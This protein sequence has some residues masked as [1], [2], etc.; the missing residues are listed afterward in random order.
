MGQSS[1]AGK[2]GHSPS[3]ASGANGR[4][5]RFGGGPAQAP[6]RDRSRAGSRSRWRANRQQRTDP[7]HD[8]ADPNPN[9]IANEPIRLFALACLRGEWPP[10]PLRRRAGPGTRS[11]SFAS[12]FSFAMACQPAAANRPPPRPRG[13]EPERAPERSNSGYSPS[14]ASGA[15]GRSSR[16]G[17]KPLPKSRPS[18]TAFSCAK[19]WQPAAANRPCPRPR[20]PE[21]ERARERCDLLRA[22]HPRLTQLNSSG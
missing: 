8:H 7:L 6:D 19:A 4:P 11:R 15:N 18:A 21:P 10:F 2:G 16:F 1:V 3:L 14:L 5:S 9:V 20:E 13:P 12:G 17:G 22:L